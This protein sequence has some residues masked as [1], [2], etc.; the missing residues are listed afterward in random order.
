MW[1]PGRVVVSAV[2][3][4]E[5]QGPTEIRLDPHP[6]GLPSMLNKDEGGS[7]NIKR[8]VAERREMGSVL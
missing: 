5:Q 3:N 4:L 8:A 2:R 6:P 7:T 1:R